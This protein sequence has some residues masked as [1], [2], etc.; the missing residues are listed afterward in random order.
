VF[1]YLVPAIVFLMPRAL[2]ATE[3]TSGWS[4]GVFRWVSEGISSHWGLLAVW[5]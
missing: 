2:I 4:G 1:F 3:P 5:C